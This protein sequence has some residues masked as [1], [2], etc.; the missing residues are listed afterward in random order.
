MKKGNGN[1]QQVRDH[2]H[3]SRPPV[4]YMCANCFAPAP[5]QKRVCA[6]CGNEGTI[7]SRAALS[8][9]VGTFER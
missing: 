2:G 6:G 5:H 7:V 9:A 3:L 8:K 1:N 4:D